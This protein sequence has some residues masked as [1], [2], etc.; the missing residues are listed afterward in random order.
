MQGNAELRSLGRRHTICP[1]RL[2][3]ETALA[4]QIPTVATF[5]QIVRA[6]IKSSQ[7]GKRALHTSYTYGLCW[8]FHQR[9]G[10]ARETPLRTLGA[11]DWK[12]VAPSFFFIWKHGLPIFIRC[13]NLDG[14]LPITIE[15]VQSAAYAIHGAV[16]RTPARHSQTLSKIAHAEIFLKFENFQFT[17]SFKER[18]ALNKLLS[19]SVYQ[20]AHGVVAMSAGNHAQAVAY[21][22]GKL[23]IRATIVMPEATPFNKVKHTKD[24]GA[25]VIIK[26]ASLSEAAEEAQFIATHDGAT[27]I[28]P[29]DDAHVIAGQGTV[30][31]EM[32]ADLPDLDALVIPVGG[33]G[34]ISG[35][36]VAAKAIKPH[37]EI[38][39]VQTQAFPSMFHAMQRTDATYG[40]QTIAE[41]I[42]VKQPGV[43][44]SQIIRQTV[45]EILLASEAQIE[46]A[47]A[48]ILEVEKVVVE[49][50]AAAA[51]AAV[52]ANRKR[53][54]GM[55]LGLVL[56]GGNIDMRLLT[57]V[58]LRELTREGRI[59]SLSIAIEDKP[60]FLARIAA[61]ISDAGG[62]IIDVHHDRMSTDHSAKSATLS[63]TFEARDV[64]HAMEVR[65]RLER[66]GFQLQ[67]S[68]APKLRD[69]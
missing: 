51:F 41:G 21:H 16:E 49:G 19:L 61:V 20:R 59:Q 13:L 18:G 36:A 46:S 42:A 25:K 66:A 58:I 34:L 57:N 33:G 5:Q 22:A 28:H 35:M 8:G 1:L 53:F 47:L 3:L 11:A 14:S 55:K 38:Y 30:A 26:G 43:L 12:P 65:H 4:S 2:F 40:T 52:Q 54:E 31:L 60:G 7:E 23:G 6:R 44:A 15:D 48:Q 64:T 45:N 39:G 37:M 29:Y 32:L 50:A 10:C 67:G 69:L 62:N 17:A 24:F 56:S 68:A 63:L 27:F 9:G